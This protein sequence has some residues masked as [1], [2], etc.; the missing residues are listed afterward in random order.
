[1]IESGIVTAGAL[2]LRRGYAIFGFD[3]GE[4]LVKATRKEVRAPDPTKYFNGP[5]RAIAFSTD[6][7]RLAL[8][9]ESGLS[10]CLS[11]ESDQKWTGQQHNGNDGPVTAIDVS[12]SGT[13]I[14][15]HQN[16]CV[17]LWNGVTGE[18]ISVI[19]RDRTSRTVTI[20]QDG[21]VAAIG[22][23]EGLYIRDTVSGDERR[24]V[25]G[26]IA[27]ARFSPDGRTLAVASIENIVKIF[28]SSNA[29]DA[30]ALPVLWRSRVR[31]SVSNLAVTNDCCLGICR[32]DGILQFWS[33]Y[34]N[35]LTTITPTNKAG[36]HAQKVWATDFDGD[37]NI[38]PLF[39]T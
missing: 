17:T 7:R 32:N 35:E 27:V 38:L 19:R 16:N 22:D 13:M 33:P 2:S 23:E 29:L 26:N 5:V 36:A 18:T 3:N 39:T 25:R 34:T 31:G 9:G 10:Y 6:G 1:M 24:Y 12:N 15:G 20:T 14:A 28:D 11:T 30:N 21:R 37:G 4:I 8:G